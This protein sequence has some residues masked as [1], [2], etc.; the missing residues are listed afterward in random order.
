MYAALYNDAQL[1]VQAIHNECGHDRWI[2]LMVYRPKDDPEGLPRLIVFEDLRIVQRFVNRNITLEM[3]KKGW[4][5]GSISLIT[6]DIRL[7]KERGWI[8]DVFKWPRQVIGNKDLIVG[9]EIHEFAGDV[10]VL[11]NGVPKFTT[12]NDDVLTNQL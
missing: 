10:E 3:V 5:R 6:D 4:I 2:P 9:F 7:I 11:H 12:K 1:D 8:L